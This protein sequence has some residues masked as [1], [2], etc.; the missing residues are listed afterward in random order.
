[1]GQNSKL[2]GYLESFRMAPDK[3]GL[4]LLL[5]LHSTAVGEIKEALITSLLSAV[6]Y[7]VQA[8][9]SGKFLKLL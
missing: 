8:F 1:M 6:I 3:I 2:E 9:N 7:T 5:P 4:L